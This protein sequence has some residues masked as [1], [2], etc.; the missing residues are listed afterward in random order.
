MEF[1]YKVG[2]ENEIEN[3]EK[4]ENVI[5]NFLEGI[6]GEKCSYVGSIEFLSKDAECFKGQV[7]GI[8]IPKEKKIQIKKESFF[9][10]YDDELQKINNREALG[11]LIH[12]V[13][14][15]INR[16]ELEKLFLEIENSDNLGY[17][18]VGMSNLLDEY[19]ASYKAHRIMPGVYS[20]VLD[21]IEEIPED[22][23][24]KRTDPLK[25]YLTI[26]NMIAWFIG[27]T[28][29]I[30]ENTRMDE[31]K[32][33]CQK[34]EDERFVYI[35]MLAKEAIESEKV[36]N[37]KMYLQKSETFSIELLKYV[38]ADFQLLKEVDESMKN[39]ILR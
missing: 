30:Y 16:H 12:E 1:L 25:L 21:Y 2:N 26:V 9:D 38:G 31:W 24:K 33:R 8:A 34:I 23:S 13:Q 39:K 6:F 37:L 10:Y 11:T 14:H 35:L 4:I 19:L 15:L 22:V 32:K 36:N 27:E 5:E 17:V 18:K 28:D 20:G 7:E 3:R 29:A